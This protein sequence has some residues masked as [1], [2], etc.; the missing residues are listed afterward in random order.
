ML[1]CVE[2]ERY[3]STASSSDLKVRSN[4][5]VNSLP[6]SSK[7]VGGGESDAQNSKA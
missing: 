5:F 4:C 6:H 7:D 2:E 3:S 1:A